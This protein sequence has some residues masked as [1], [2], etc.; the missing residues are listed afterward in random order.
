MRGVPARRGCGDDRGLRDRVPAFRRV[1]QVA[2][3]HQRGTYDEAGGADERVI[4]P[5]CGVHRGDLTVKVAP[6]R[7]ANRA[8]LAA[9]AAVDVAI[10][11]RVVSNT[12]R[13][14]ASAWPRR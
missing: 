11:C 3:A 8:M 4:S 13:S 5:R 2:D 9:N 12:S 6:T 1:E 7:V 10:S 14:S